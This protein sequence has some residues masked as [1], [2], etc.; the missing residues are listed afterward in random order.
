MSKTTL[1]FTRPVS[2]GAHGSFAAGEV[3]DLPADVAAAII[4]VGKAYQ[5]THP[6]K[7]SDKVESTAVNAV[8]EAAIAAPVPVA[9]RKKAAK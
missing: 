6:T 2:V 4:G 3:A 8:S 9:K 7:D 5:F 1:R